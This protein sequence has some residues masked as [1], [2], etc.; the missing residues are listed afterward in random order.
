VQFMEQL[1]L[2]VAERIRDAHT[3]AVVK[4]EKS[5][6]DDETYGRGQGDGHV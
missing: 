6:E 3:G 5:Y 2:S 4:S 1:A